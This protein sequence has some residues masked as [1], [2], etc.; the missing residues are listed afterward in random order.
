MTE[1]PEKETTSQED[2][3]SIGR[4]NVV[5]ALAS[6]PVFGVFLASFFTKK[7][8]DDFKRK[9]ILDGLGVTDQAPAAPSPIS[10]R[11]RGDTLRL[12]IIGYGGQ[13]ESVV[14]AAGFAHP[15]WPKPREGGVRRLVPDTRFE[16]FLSQDDLNVELVGVC[17]LFDV[18]AERALAA[19]R[20]DVRPGGG[21]GLE[22]ARRFRHYQEMLD[23]PDIDAVIIGTPDHWHAQITID[24]VHAGKHVYCEKA[25][26]RTEEEVFRVAEAVR[27]S[28]VVYQLG[29]QNRQLESHRK[30]REIIDKIILG[31]IT[32][33]ETTTNRN[34]PNGAWVYDIHPEAS[35]ETVDWEQFQEPAPNKVPFSKERFFRWRCWFDYGTGLAG[36]LLSHE[37]DALNQILG[38]GIPKSAVASGGVYFF[39]DGREAPD[40][41]Q[42]VY[43]YPDRDLTVVYS[44]TLAN[45]RAR[46]KVLMGHDASME[47]GSGLRVMV[48]TGSTRYEDWLEEEVVD[49][50]QPL[51]SYQPGGGGI[52]AITSAT[53]E[54]FAS[55]GLLYTYQ[56]GRRVSTLHLHVKEWVDSIRNGSQ[57]S[58]GIEQGIQEAITCDL[59]TQSYRLG[60]RVEWDPVQ[61]KIV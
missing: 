52:D 48:T 18:R 13:G 45:D 33:V 1:A 44:A 9:R 15:D 8:R 51:L 37:Y 50:K 22:G 59:A 26:T 57:P 32:I 61:K 7:A 17:D 12:G 25:M 60:R 40:V 24:A 27:G 11:T 6:I 14:R 42:V 49:A 29:H 23:S 53:E 41:F 3:P 31:K 2:S 56:G 47:V 39:K 19:S 54:Y 5:V 35:P 28:D 16:G 10:S 38:L 58:C 46:G 43:E 4:R 34:S 21:A 55:R 36:D 20:N 30:S